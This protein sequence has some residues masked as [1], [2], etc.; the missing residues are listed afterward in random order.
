[1]TTT[2]GTPTAAEKLQELNAKINAAMN[3]QEGLQEPSVE[4]Q[5]DP[6]W[7]INAR[8]ALSVLRAVEAGTP[9]DGGIAYVR[10]FSDT[11]TILTDDGEIWTMEADVPA[12]QG[13]KESVK[14]DATE[15]RRLFHFFYPIA[16]AEM[17]EIALKLDKARKTPE[18]DAGSVAAAR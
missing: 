14:L 3:A 16:W 17:C 4:V 6:R 8:E 11:L 9:G 10:K 2:N 1:M 18:D 12:G 7:L 5:E 15:M 13:Y